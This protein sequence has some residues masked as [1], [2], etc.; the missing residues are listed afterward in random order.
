MKANKRPKKHFDLEES[1]RLREIYTIAAQLICEKGFDAT[2]MDD[3]ADAVGITK[4]GI[5]HYIHGKREML[6]QLMTYGMQRLEQRVIDPARAI[7]DPEQRL[8]AIISSHALLITEGSNSKGN[9]PI[10][11]VTDEVS[12]LA[13]AHRRAIEK[14][15]R[16]YL[17]LVRETLQELHDSQKLANVDV[18][19]AAFSLMGIMLWLSRWYRPHGRLTQEQVAGEVSRIALG[20]V[21]RCPGSDK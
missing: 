6:Y 9:N 11:I 4:A 1:D 12:G 8:K 20:G 14:R 17:D 5:Y 3:I 7:I 21:L 19:V 2:S 10:T 16:A 18:T 15:K 13:P